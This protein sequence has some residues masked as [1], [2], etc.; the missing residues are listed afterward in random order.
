MLF[1]DAEKKIIM[2]RG[3]DFV[4]KIIKFLN[5]I[6]Y[7]FKNEILLIIAGTNNDIISK[8]EEFIIELGNKLDSNP[9]LLFITCHGHIAK[10]VSFM[11]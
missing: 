4:E 7:K 6:N 11:N 1:N 9:H 10:N 8:I 3:Y 5:K 2:S